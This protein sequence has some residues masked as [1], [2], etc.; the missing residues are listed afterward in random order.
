MSRI[1]AI[2][3]G[4][5]RV[6]LAVTDPLRIIASPLTTIENKEVWSFLKSYFEKEEVST[7]IVGWPAHTDGQPSAMTK[8][9][10]Q[11]IIQLKKTFPTQKILQQDERYTSKMA[12]Q[13]MIQSGAKKK[14]RR[15]KG[16]LDKI[17]ATLILQSYLEELSS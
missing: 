9:V 12:L 6:G 10:E 7:I 13:S 16:N 5:K 1:L 14:A 3:Y 15:Q 11:F 17:S 8:A 4:L 2:D